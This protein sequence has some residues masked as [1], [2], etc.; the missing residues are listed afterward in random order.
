MDSYELI[1]IIIV[2]TAVFAYVNFRFIRLPSTVGLMVMSLILSIFIV[3]FGRFFPTFS[4]QITTA[5]ATIDFRKLLLDIMLS[6]LLFAGAIHIDAQRLKKN[7]ISIIILASVGMLLSTAIVGTLLYLL[8]AA[9][10]HPV[11]LIY[12]LLFGALISPT[13]PVAVLGILQKAN[14]PESAEMKITGE[15]LFNDGVAI[16]IFLTLLRIAQTG[17]EDISAGN[18]LSLFLEEVGGGLIYGA[19]LGYVFFLLLKSVNNYEVEVLLTIAMVMGGYMLAQ[20][21]HLSAPIAIVTAG[22]IMGNK[23]RQ[24]EGMSS[25][26]RAYLSKF[27]EMIDNILNAILFLLIGFEMLVVDINTTLIII[28]CITFLIVLLARFLSVLLP[29][30][31]LRIFTNFEKHTVTILT[32]GALRGG[33]SVAIALSLP[34][35][36]YR[37]QFVTITYIVV[38]FSIIGQGLTIGKLLKRLQK[39]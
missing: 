11:G 6:F 16:V 33:I 26:T 21:L 19:V 9:F 4:E 28:G 27:W 20:V 17:I 36:M 23:G 39:N 7:R 32:L 3:L 18:V 29:F 24:N 14:I 2:I 12:C 25:A 30:A 13:D 34:P 38:V 37:D 35:N 22:I 8:L 1:T 15:S 31:V 10:H 5:V